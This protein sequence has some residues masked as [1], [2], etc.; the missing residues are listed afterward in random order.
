M[1]LRSLCLVWVTAFL[2]TVFPTNTE[3]AP[4][5][6]GGGFHGGGFHASGF[7]GSFAGGRAVVSP[8]FRAG[9]I[10][11]AHGQFFRGP[12]LAFTGFRPFYAAYRPY[13]GLNGFVRYGYRPYYG[14][15]PYGGLGLG[16]WAYPYYGY[17]AGYPIYV[18]PSDYPVED[19]DYDHYAPPASLD[20]YQSGYYPP[21]VETA[22]APAAPVGDNCAHVTVQV[23]PDA[24][25]WFDDYQ[26]EQKGELR[27]FV[28][29]A[30]TPGREYSYDIRARW[31][32]NGK[33][34]ERA[35]KIKVHANMTVNVDLRGP[36]T[37]D[38]PEGR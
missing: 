21:E 16:L 28:S 25:L 14:V 37:G 3:A 32:E 18:S 4:G 17:Y 11:V 30:L 1:S 24:Q 12:G 10:G 29:P 7:H 9:A 19:Y 2:T 8:A 23:P 26:A 35:R 34:M 20:T 22:D 33:R 31:M 36:Q 27:S 5:R 13:W 15:W 6:G 38:R